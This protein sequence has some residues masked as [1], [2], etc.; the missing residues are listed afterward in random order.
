MSRSAGRRMPGRSLRSALLKGT[1]VAALSAVLAASPAHAQL[2]AIRSALGVPANLGTPTPVPTNTVTAVTPT[3]SQIL[4]RH[5]AY[6]AR[7]QQAAGLIQQANAAARAAAAAAAQSVPNGLTRGG[8]DPVAITFTSAQDPTGLAVWEGANKPTQTQSGSTVDV[9]ISQTQSRALLS[10]NTFNVG[11]N[12]TLTFNQQGNTDWIAVNRIVGNIDP[13]TG[14][15][16][17]TKD[18]SPTQILGKIKADGTV[19][20]LDRAGVMF[21]ANSQV[22]LHSLLASSLELGSATVPATG[23]TLRDVSLQER[24]SSFLTRGILTDTVS[25]LVSAVADEAHGDVAVNVGAQ[26]NATGGYVILAG[27]K[28]SSAGE[29]KNTVGGQVSLEAGT[30]ID[31]TVSSG[32]ADSP[33]PFVRGLVLSSSGGGEVTLAGSIDTPQGY[34][35]LG[36][37][38]TGTVNM[39]GFLSSTTSV[40]RNGK[41]SLIG[42]TVNV[43]D[44]AAMTITPDASGATIPQSADSVAAFKSS[45]IDIGSHVYANQ[46][47]RLVPENGS[48]S[49]ALLPAS[50]TIGRDSTIVAPNANVSIGGHTGDPTRTVDLLPGVESKVDIEDNAVIDVSGVADVLL[51]PS[52]NVLEISPAK[53]NELRDTPNYR[54]PT[55]DGSFTLNGQTLFVDPRLNG[56]RADGVA[57]I[58][59]PLIEAGSL[60][61]QIGIT[62]PELMTR[63]GNVNLATLGFKPG[64]AAPN[65]SYIPSINIASNAVLDF[66]GGWVRYSAGS[67]HYSKLLTADGR[68][69]D[70]SKAD[71]NDDFVAV[72]NGFVEQLPQLSDPTV[73][74]NSILQGATYEPGYV[75]GHD[76]GSLTIKAPTGDL[77]GTFHGEAVAGERQIGEGEAATKASTLPGDIRKLQAARNQLPASGLLHIQ[78]VPGGNIVIGTPGT[79]AAPGTMVL[80]AGKLNAASLGAL[81]LQTSGAITV[82]ASSELNLAAGGAFNAEAG[83]SITFDGKISIPSGSISARTY[84]TV[85]GNIFDASDD[86]PANGILASD[87]APAG[88]FDIT[89]NAGAVLSTQGRWTNDSL[90]TDPLLYTGPGYTSGGSITLVSAPHVEVLR[91]DLKSAVDISGSILLNQGSL[92]DTSGGG[93]VAPTGSLTLDGKGGN[94]S[95]VNQTVY[96]QLAGA[97]YN[98]FPADNSDLFRSDLTSFQISPDVQQNLGHGIVP[99][100]ITSTVSI[101][102]EIR[103]FGFKGGGSFTLVTPD[104]KFGSSD[105]GGTEVPLDFLER[106]GF[107]TLSLSSWKTALID[108]V[109][110]N[111]L[112][113][114]TGILATDAVQIRA[115]ETLNLIQSILPSILT[116]DQI[117]L[118][119]TQASGTDISRLAAIAPTN[120][121]GDWDNLP[122]NLILGGL[123]ELQVL[124]GTITG[125]P[126]A[127]ITAPR[128][129]NDGTIRIAGGTLAQSLLLPSIYV[130]GNGSRGGIGVHQLFDADGV[131]RGAGLSA[132][133]GRADSNGMFDENATNALGFTASAN[134]TH[135][136]TNRELVAGQN[137]DRP[138]YYLGLLDADQGIVLANGSVTDLSGISIRNPRASLVPGTNVPIA[139]GRIIDGGSVK[140]ASLFYSSDGLFLPQGLSER[141]YRYFLGTEAEGTSF[142]PTMTRPELKIVA[143]EGA[144]ID[145]SGASDTFDVQTAANTYTPTAVWSN[146]G[147]LSALGGGDVSRATI[148]ARGGASAARGGIFEWLN[149]VLV[150]GTSS[151]TGVVSADQIQAAGFDS[152]VARGSVSTLGDVDLNLGRSFLLRARDFIGLAPQHSARTDGVDPLPYADPDYAISM[153]ATGALSI[154][155][156]HIG[157]LGIDQT[158]AS[159]SDTGTGTLELHGDSID[160]FGAVTFRNSLADVLLDSAGDIRLIGVQPLTRTLTPETSTDDPSLSGQVIAGGN[161][162]FRASQ[163]YATTGSGNLQNLT[164]S[165][166]TAFV[167]PF[168]IGSAGADSTIRFES[169]GKPAPAIPYSA[170]SYIS[171]RAP[172]IEQAGI[173]RAPLGRIDLGSTTAF[174]QKT[175]NSMI[176]LGP[177]KSVTLEP[178]SI[179]SV[180]LG[181]L[182]VPY[183]TTVDLTDNYFGP[184]SSSPLTAPPAAELRLGGDN[185][186][187][188][189]GATVDA[190]GG[191]GD[192]YAYEFVS[193]TGGSRDVLSRFN[194]DAFSS[195]NGLQYPDGRQ[196]YAIVPVGSATPALYD[197]IYSSDYGSLYAG[198]AGKIVHLEGGNGITAGDYLL[199]PGQYAML[200][201]AMRLVENVGS[202]AP[203][204]GASATLRDGSVV[205]AGTY[206]T[207]GTSESDWQRRSFTVQTQSVFGKYS[208]IAMTS[209]TTRFTDIAT[210]DGNVVPR[211]PGDAARIV[212]NPALSLL[213]D[214][215]FDTDP[216]ESGRGS[217]VDIAADVIDVVSQITSPRDGALTLVTGDLEKLNAASLFLGGIRTDLADGSTNLDITAHEINIINDVGHPLSAPEILLAV[218]GIGSK[219]HLADGASIIATGTLS[220]TR[221]GDYN[222]A[223]YTLDSGGNFVSENSGAGAVF[224][225][226]NGVER[227]VNRSGA[228]A[229]SVTG[230]PVTYTVG[231]VNLAGNSLA[232]DSS[233]QLDFDASST[234]D[235]NHIAI[236]GDNI[237]FSSRTYG[238]SGLVITP[239]LEQAFGVA[240]SLTIRA[241]NVIGFTAGV[242]NFND[243]R[244]LAPGVKLIRTQ[245]DGKGPLSVTLNANNVVLGNRSSDAGACRG[246][247][248]FSC[249]SA[250]NDLA[251]N[252]DT[253]TFSSGVFHTYGF[254]KS[255]ALSATDGMYYNGVGAFDVGGANLS[256]TTPF[257]V[258][259]G[260]GAQPKNGE[261][262]QADLELR[263]TGNVA[264]AAGG[265]IATP[266]GNLAPGARLA[267]GSL[268]APA[269]NVSI[270]GTLLRATAGT[271]EAYSD[272]DVSITGAARLET[273]SYSQKF[274]D[275]ADLS[276]LSHLTATSASASRRHCRSAGLR[277]PREHLT[278]SRA[279]ARSIFWARSTLQHRTPARA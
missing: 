73:Y 193:G 147:T 136:L 212:V 26:I 253:L 204:P 185:V 258:D 166:G 244:L 94:V 262:P 33:D 83:R 63:G 187:I 124:G 102:G 206:G 248:V 104:L 257:I 245:R 229:D 62:A 198:D 59:S 120:Q 60:A 107:G 157:L 240:D 269:Q 201:G 23:S 228:L 112:V 113:G 184:V 141:P 251:I 115:G 66:S 98:V 155:A 80:D 167:R 52:R 97:N 260:S 263:S 85:F 221:S 276:A 82:D 273:T 216:A 217:E 8:L 278:C 160:I 279:T 239:E 199:H 91:P 22:N 89:V 27:P 75:E 114:K 18:I 242:H 48:S 174:G 28:V 90:V 256:L 232:L 10:W 173:L 87:E 42:G 139:T 236:S 70:I 271:I 29:I 224:R 6:E 196:V 261:D 254:D 129:Y 43:G 247:G 25:G 192:I 128:I 259:R 268:S 13:K 226:A 14:L 16:D 47:G 35:S 45:Q 208:R 106:T 86:L 100:E 191:T 65:A 103:S 234:L 188:L 158:V 267:I 5:Q 183:G 88:L 9:N 222:V 145:L 156:P 250:G 151:E 211:L 1:S 130:T 210:S 275:A 134:S 153:G 233:R 202:V 246:N 76:A 203:V 179:T 49:F 142:D 71:P 55:T 93:Y 207:A 133:F 149:P 126:Q 135:I 109:F 30:Q 125:A 152:F 122:A 67:V 177:T 181:D 272:T 154:T 194:S 127:S 170:G 118:L 230:K 220:D 163:V 214:G 117:N 189:N 180:S 175:T 119:G 264:I 32:D 101:D 144:S 186:S 123:T 3:M 274:G 31:A 61:S 110:D 46:S 238:I 237:S 140:A 249:G 11:A 138:I 77:N 168:I 56:V 84:G 137:N 190:S 34:I 72:G 143:D 74:A 219:L 78:S 132:V 37:D 223:H 131:D 2:A 19:Y 161:L 148:N 41:I 169:N 200:P 255:V 68:V 227:L 20:I 265:N 57:W 165:N 44:G 171:V 38:H 159:L 39:A 241:N 79:E 111:G 36:T 277:D 146:A 164:E 108:N 51:D 69:V 213:I 92:L 270:D 21:G 209:G 81:S 95:L 99:D 162:T 150:Q 24:N 195:N 225:L 205:V 215:N 7:V 54:D 197:P 96:F 64:Q 17:P 218:D 172:H 15:L 231:Q 243:L 105:G 178:G 53:R 58:G 50:I 252:S 182:K 12:T 176:V 266:T 4:A 116:T 235:V 40:S 121:L